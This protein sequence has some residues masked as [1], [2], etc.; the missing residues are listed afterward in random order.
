MC[1]LFWRKLRQKRKVTDL[2]L[3]PPCA[4]TLKKHTARARYIAKIWKHA[5]VP[6]QSLDLFQNNGSLEIDRNINWIERAYLTNVESLFKETE[7]KKLKIMFKMSKQ[8]NL[9]RMMG[10]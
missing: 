9:M 5:Y 6:Y 1:Q 3:L 2:S 7:D 10:K 8:M 4:S